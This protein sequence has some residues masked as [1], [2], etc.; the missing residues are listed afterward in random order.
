M[1][2]VSMGP[3][4]NM[5]GRADHFHSRVRLRCLPSGTCVSLTTVSG[6]LKDPVRSVSRKHSEDLVLTGRVWS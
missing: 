2:Q 5:T 4:W 1:R 6:P 3:Y